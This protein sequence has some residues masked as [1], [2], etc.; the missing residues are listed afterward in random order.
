MNSFPQAKTM[1]NKNSTQKQ[2]TKV[3]YGEIEFIDESF[4]ENELE[5]INEFM[6]GIY[7]KNGTFDNLVH[8]MKKRDKHGLSE[9]LIGKAIELFLGTKD[10]FIEKCKE[11]KESSKDKTLVE[12]KINDFT[13]MLSLLNIEERLPYVEFI[14]E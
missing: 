8:Y 5:I 6:N 1:G 9:F 14:Y 11:S 10:D 2:E 13:R 4:N 3:D 7:N 12:I